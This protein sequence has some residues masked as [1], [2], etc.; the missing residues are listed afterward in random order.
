MLH[1]YAELLGWVQSGHGVSE[2]SFEE[3]VLVETIKIRRDDKNSSLQNTIASELQSNRFKLMSLNMA[4]GSLETYT[5]V[6]ENGVLTVCNSDGL[7]QEERNFCYKLR[8]RE[9]AKGSFELIIGRSKDAG[10]TW[11]PYVK[12]IYRRK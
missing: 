1:S 12:N 9:I 4:E 8:Y 10:K 6:E 7:T 5:G 11:V 2:I 3:N